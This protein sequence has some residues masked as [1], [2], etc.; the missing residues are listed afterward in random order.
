MP[1][2]HEFV[3]QRLRLVQQKLNNEGGD[4]VYEGGGKVRQRTQPSNRRDTQARR[5][6]RLLRKFLSQ[7]REGQVLKA[8]QNWRRYLGDFLTEHRQRYREVQ[9]AYDDWWELPPYQRQR[10]TQPEK[11]PPPRVIDQ[12]GAPWIVDERLLALFDDL[13]ERL[14]KWLAED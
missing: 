13:V 10:V 8:L 7:T 1:S 4:Y 14:T 11:P 2:D 12:N 6:A 3:R 9:K 5:E